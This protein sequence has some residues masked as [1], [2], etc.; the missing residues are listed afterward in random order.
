MVKKHI[1]TTTNTA[2]DLG[3][4]WKFAYGRGVGRL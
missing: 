1:N 2:L 4:D 3:K